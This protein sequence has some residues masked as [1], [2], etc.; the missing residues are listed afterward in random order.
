MAGSGGPADRDS[1]RLEHGEDFP[2]QSASTGRFRHGAPR[3]MQITGDRRGVVF[4]RSAG[5]T[6]PAGDLWWLELESGREQLL[7][8][9]TSLLADDEEVPAAERVRRE[10]LREG[11]AGITAFSVDADGRLAAFAL[12][13]RL[14]TV[15][16]PM[17]VSDV[18]GTNPPPASQ[19]RELAVPGPVV[20]PRLS[21]DGSRVGWH[22]GG[23]L[24]LARSDGSEASPLTPDD[25]CDWGLADFVAA[26]EFDRSRGF[27]WSP[28]SDELLV[29]R[30][31]ESPVGQVWISDPARPAVPPRPVHYPTAGSPNAEVSLWRIDFA[32]DARRLLEVGGGHVDEYLTGVGWNQRGA[33]A[34]AVDRRQRHARV[35]RLAGPVGEPTSD[36]SVIA[37][38][39][40]DDWVDLQ[41]GVPLLTNDGCLITLERDT[42]NDCMRVC[43]DRVAFSPPGLQVRSVVA[44]TP[45]GVLALTADQPSTSCLTMLGYDGDVTP[46]LSGGWCVAAAQGDTVV[47]TDSAIDRPSRTRVFTTRPDWRQ[48]AEIGTLA[49]TPSV[50]PRVE[51]LSSS[52]VPTAVLWPSTD[53][54]SGAGRKLPIVMCP[55]GGPRGQRVIAAQAAY[56]DAQWLADQGFCVVIADGRGTPGVSPS[57][58]RAV[59]G[60]LA[61]GVLA[62][63]VAALDAVVAA[64]PDR[65]RSDR[66]GIMG[67]SFGGYLAALAVLSRPDRFHAA[68][69]G[70]PVTEWGLYDTGYT[71]RYLGLPEEQPEQYRRS[72]LTHRAS[73]LTRP[74]LIIHGLA[75]DNVLVAHALRLSSALLAAGRPHSVLPLNGVTHMTPQPVVAAN[76]A[77]LQ[78]DFLRGALTESVA[79]LPAGD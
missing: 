71:E 2:L 10:R 14:F 57:W 26:E 38:I 19:C 72:D 23:R 49:A 68:V 28:D 56:L 64:Y 45:A 60:D 30:V 31:D 78:V 35:L 25:G 69:A 34:V 52:V 6:N 63:Q 21:P 41:P 4:I 32:G 53:H 77:R 40:D 22:C 48:V 16:L 1:A 75:D 33:L 9:A 20:D 74:L 79:S 62:D 29:T 61:S 66:V 51:L 67:W 36:V 27:W 65:V 17:A 44:A 5:A 43:R 13:G 50:R 3:S 7:A 59:A 39:T 58:E 42:A 15:E 54:S 11:S 18:A 8:A 46:L 12:S 47:A 70:A 37:E 73:A 55:Y 24:W 76:V